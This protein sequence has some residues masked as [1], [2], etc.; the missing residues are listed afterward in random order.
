MSEPNSQTS[1]IGEGANSQEKK[2]L[3]FCSKKEN[4]RKKS[5]MSLNR[6]ANY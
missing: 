4:S 5:N 3:K 2:K 1:S 6:F